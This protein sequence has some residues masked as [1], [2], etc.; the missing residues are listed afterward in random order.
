M[1]VIFKGLAYHFIRLVERFVCS[2]KVVE[3]FC[4]IDFFCVTLEGQVVDI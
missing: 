4:N 2:K 3:G 1:S